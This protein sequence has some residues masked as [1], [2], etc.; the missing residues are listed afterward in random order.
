[1]APDEVR[2]PVGA[3]QRHEADRDDG[4]RVGDAGKVE[5]HEE[6][7][8]DVSIAKKPFRTGDHELAQ[9]RARVVALAR[10]GEDKVSD[11]FAVTEQF[12]ARVDVLVAPGDGG[13][14]EV[15]EVLLGAL[16]VPDP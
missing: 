6:G 7:L 1:M 15:G 16:R 11:G 4:W 12:V 14:E 3:L 9:G 10:L 8:R 5:M 13:G 2:L